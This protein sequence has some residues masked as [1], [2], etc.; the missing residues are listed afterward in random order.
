MKR[1]LAVWTFFGLALVVNPH[2]ACSSNGEDEDF[3]YSEQEMKAVVL[4]EWQG[5]AVLDGESVEFTLSLEQA[6]AK[7]S[8]QSVSAPPFQ[9]QCG[10]RSFVKP[11]A[12][13]ISMSTMPLAGSI[14]SEHPLLNGPVEGL[15]M[16]SRILNPSELHLELEDGTHL[17]GSLKDQ[18]I[19]E[20]EVVADEPV[21][22]FTLSRP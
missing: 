7:S 13:C 3:T 10:S 20:G 16:A 15:A 4:G 2:L 19:T 8:T 6:S 21:G 17:D 5:T 1:N 18:A 11:A 12:A 14:V 22:T 9:P